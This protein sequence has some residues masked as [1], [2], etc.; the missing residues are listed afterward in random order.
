LVCCTKKNLATLEE[1]VE[2]SSDGQFGT[3]VERAHFVIAPESVALRCHAENQISDRQ[4]SG[5][6]TKMSTCLTPQ[7]VLQ[8]PHDSPPQAFEAELGTMYLCICEFDDSKWC[9]HTFLLC[10]LDVDT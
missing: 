8:T 2:N 4:N 6:V 1:G 7:I 10:N 3:N 9:Q 5:K